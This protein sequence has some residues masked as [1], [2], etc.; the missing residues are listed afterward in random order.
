MKI[1]HL[2]RLRG[3]TLAETLIVVF[4]YSLI[5]FACYMVL[6]AGLQSWKV[7][8]VRVELTQ[9]LR[10]AMDW[11]VDDI[12]QAG[13]SSISNVPADGIWYTTITFKRSAGVSSG[14]IVWSSEDYVY[15]RDTTLRQI[16]RTKGA[17]VKTIAQYIES[18]QIRRQASTPE[19]V[20]VSLQAKNNPPLGPVLTVNSSFKIKLRN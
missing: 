6:S 9:E 10:K 5:A 15:S 20:E 2:G 7:N 13:T 8:Q 16:K 17:E 19:I 3:V 1:S 4:V 12:R 14:S 11:M 18:L